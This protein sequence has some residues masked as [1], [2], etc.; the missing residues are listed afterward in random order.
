[1]SALFVLYFWKNSNV[2]CIDTWEVSSDKSQ[3]LDYCFDN[4]ES[5]FDKNLEN[6]K[7]NKIKDNSKN[8]LKKLK[9]NKILYDYIYIDG[10]HNGSVIL[11]DAVASF[12]LLNKNG[13]LIFDDIQT[14]YNEISI[15]PHDAFKNFYKLYSSKIK[16]LYLKNLAIIKKN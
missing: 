16:I 9:E 10:S 12:E 3:I 5:S 11:N 1:M 7:F 4:V 6:Y 15:Q 8:A 14:I 2:T 13:V